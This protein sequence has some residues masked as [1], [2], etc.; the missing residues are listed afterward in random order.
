MNWWV[1]SDSYTSS[2]KTTVKIINIDREKS[3]K[4]KA[5]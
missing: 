3:N 4:Q 2:E 5:V 1:M